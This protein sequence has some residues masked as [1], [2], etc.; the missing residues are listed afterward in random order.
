M[1]AV[2]GIL[3]LLVAACGKEDLTDAEESDPNA[4]HPTASQPDDANSSDNMGIKTAEFH[5]TADDLGGVLSGEST[6]HLYEANGDKSPRPEL[7]M[8]ASRASG[9]SIHLALTDDAQGPPTGEYTIGE[10]GGGAWET[11]DGVQ[12]VAREGVVTVTSADGGLLKGTFDLWDSRNSVGV[13]GSFSGKWNLECAIAAPPAE[14]AAAGKDEDGE[15]EPQWKTDLALSSD[16]C[17]RA[18]MD[19]RPPQQQ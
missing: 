2:I 16:F 4:S 8:D 1:L 15:V 12:N 5:M 13:R 11:A 10:V 9:E 14:A 17:S 7:T 3:T 19:L 18:A 6:Y